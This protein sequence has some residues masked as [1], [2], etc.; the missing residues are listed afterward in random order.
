MHYG[1]SPGVEK[2]CV[3]VVDNSP[4]HTQLLAD[5]LKRDRALEVIT[6]GSDVTD[7][8]NI[9]VARNVDV[10]AISS[11]LD[12]HPG[13]GFELLRE[14]RSVSRRFRA[15]VLLDTSQETVVLEAF[16]AGA[17]G[18]FSRHGSVEALSKCIHCVHEGQI[19]GNSEEI[20]LVLEALA[21]APSVRA[22][23]AKGLDLLSKREKEVVQC[24][25]EGLSNREIA[26]RLSLSQ[27]T[28][29]N[30][31]FRVFDKLGVSSRVELLFMTLSQGNGSQPAFLDAAT[32]GGGLG[33]AAFLTC[34][35][36]AEG[37]EPAA[38]VALAE[39]CSSR[40]SPKDLGDAYMWYLIAD[41]QLSHAR[42]NIS[43]LMTPEQVLEAEQRAARWLGESQQPNKITP[44]R[45][46]YSRV[47]SS[48]QSGFVANGD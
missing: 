46:D 28:I 7:I 4:I 15:V 20:S 26:D 25:A 23:D 38:Q 48:E 33:E 13:R 44:S 30:Y 42:K 39:I 21:S 17:R 32:R 27:H 24:L 3:L 22:V 16:R 14:L 6:A 45:A 1:Q 34:T 2:I 12:G 40:R 18:I 8:P 36:A 35:K 31:L 29:K 9:I 47:A 37:G 19:W 10:V 43:R 5:A 11:N 41:Q